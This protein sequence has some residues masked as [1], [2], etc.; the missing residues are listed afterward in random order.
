MTQTNTLYNATQGDLFGINAL[1]QKVRNHFSRRQIDGKIVAL[2][3]ANAD[4]N[5]DL[6]NG[7]IGLKI[8]PKLAMRDNII[9]QLGNGAK[10]I[11]DIVVVW[12]EWNAQIVNILH[13]NLY[14]ERRVSA[15]LH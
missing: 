4:I 2:I 8:S 5:V 7:C 11:C 15:K 14:L 9:K 6:G 1:K 13:D 3:L 10:S 12:D